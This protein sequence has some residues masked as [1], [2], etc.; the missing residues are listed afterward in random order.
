[1]GEDA[2]ERGHHGAITHEGTGY[3]TDRIATVLH[4]LF[5]KGRATDRMK[6]STW[7]DRK[8]TTGLVGR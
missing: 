7:V 6:T 5:R 2:V 4:R 1:M 3:F 8:E